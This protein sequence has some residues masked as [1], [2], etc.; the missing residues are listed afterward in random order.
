MKQVTKNYFVSP[1]I[2]PGDI[3][4]LKEQGFEIIVCNRPDRE[5]P[6]QPDFESINKECSRLGLKFYNHPISPGDLNLER[7]LKT[8][9]MLEESKKTLAY[10]RTGTRCIMLWACAE[11][12]NKEVK[13][14]LKISQ[15][16]G[17]D[18]NHMEE[19]L[20]SLKIAS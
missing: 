5:E 13:E 10:C 16:A 14:I 18:L 8:K 17:Y 7:V 4:L 11:V 12:T 9:S 1:Q 15:E 6:N 3:G 19:I 20:S 2:D